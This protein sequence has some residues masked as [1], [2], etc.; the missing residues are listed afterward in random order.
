MPS[1]A[2]SSMRSATSSWLPTSAVPAP[3]RTVEVDLLAAPQLAH[4]R[5]ELSGALVARV[6]VEVVAERALFL[7]VASGD[8]VEQQPPA[9]LA[10][11]GGGHL[12]G[13]ATAHGQFA[14]NIYQHIHWLNEVV[15]TRS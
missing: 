3:P 8:D 7:A 5:K 1:V 11:E 14:A 13:E 10:L 15:R 2:Y 4:D 6:L 9:A 12:R